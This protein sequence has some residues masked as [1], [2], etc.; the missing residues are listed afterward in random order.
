MEK[1]TQGS[2]TLFQLTTLSRL[3]EGGY[4]K[5]FTLIELMIVVVIVAIFAAIAIPSYQEYVRRANVAM[6]Q[7]EMQKIAEQLERHKARNFT[8]R[9]FDPNFLYNVIGPMGSVTLP[10]GATG[11]AIKYTIT[12]TDA[13]APTRLL[14][15]TTAPTIRA[16]N[17]I[18]IA[19]T[20]D[21]RNY[22]LLMTSAG[23]R[24]KN[25]TKAN[26]TNTGCGTQATGREDW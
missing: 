2:T 6:V 17:W 24:C 22:D 3:K 12:I 15:D 5:G 20:A 8:Y 1:I 21:V 25:K 26:V 7:Q 14:T 19:R 9:G 13:E 11:P 18:M 23:V 4:A 10:R 16:R